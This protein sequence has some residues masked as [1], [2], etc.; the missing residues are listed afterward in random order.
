MEENAEKSE[1]GR[2]AILSVDR[3]MYRTAS[4]SDKKLNQHVWLRFEWRDSASL[5]L[6][7]RRL[8]CLDEGN[9]EEWQQNRSEK[10]K[11]EKP[12]RDLSCCG[13]LA[14]GVPCGVLLGSVRIEK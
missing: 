8:S 11:A 10:E 4:F 3:G 1:V 6:V 13:A 12:Q 14:S 9:G 7:A 5:C 2:R